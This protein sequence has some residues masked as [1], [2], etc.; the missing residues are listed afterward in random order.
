MIQVIKRNQLEQNPVGKHLGRLFFNS[1]A[2]KE[3]KKI[4]VDT[5]DSINSKDPIYK[6]F[7]I[8]LKGL[9][10]L[11]VSTLIITE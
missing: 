5:K 8:I 6:A 2:W 1:T 7:N 11:G 3:N 10:L 9:A 4:I